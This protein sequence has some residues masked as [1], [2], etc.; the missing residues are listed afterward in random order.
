MQHCMI[1]DLWLG[2]VGLLVG[3]L[4]LAAWIGW[5]LCRDIRVRLPAN[6][7]GLCPGLR[8]GDGPEGLT[9]WMCKTIQTIAGK[10]VDEVLARVKALADGAHS[11]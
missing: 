1:G 2:I 4:L 6:D 7:F 5:G 10:P 3:P 9:D 11:A 8:Q